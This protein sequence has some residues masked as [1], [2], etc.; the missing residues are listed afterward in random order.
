MHKPLPFVNDVST[1]TEGA[2][3]SN[4]LFFF[5]KW[6]EQSRRKKRMQTFTNH[7]IATESAYRHFDIPCNA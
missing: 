2:V 3:S 7:E 6:N 4:V 5:R 1:N